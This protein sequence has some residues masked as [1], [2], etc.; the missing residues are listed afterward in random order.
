VRADSGGG[1]VAM[2]AQHAAIED[3]RQVVHRRTM[4]RWARQINVAVERPAD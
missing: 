3:F 1:T 4:A 2:A